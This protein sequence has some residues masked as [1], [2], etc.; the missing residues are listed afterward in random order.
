MLGW[1]SGCG[2]PNLPPPHFCI[3]VHLTGT[4]YFVKYTGNVFGNKPSCVMWKRLF[5]PK[6]SGSIFLP[7][8]AAFLGK[9]SSGLWFFWACV[10][11]SSFI[12]KGMIFCVF[13]RNYGTNNFLRLASLHTVYIQ[14]FTAKRGSYSLASP[15]APCSHT[16]TR[17]LPSSL[18]RS[19]SR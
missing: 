3:F 9:K 14:C 5:S 17:S 18:A 15:L 6:M 7:F 2:C 16:L 1:R 19:R 8:C 13:V 10:W 11:S 4:K 12:W